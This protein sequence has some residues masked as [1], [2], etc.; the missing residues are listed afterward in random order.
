MKIIDFYPNRGYFL[1]GNDAEFLLEL[2]L[3]RPEEIIIG[4]EIVNLTKVVFSHNQSFDLVAGAHQI[5]LRWTTLPI[6]QKGYGVKVKIYKSGTDQLLGSVSTAFDVLTNWTDFPRYGYLCDF[7]KDRPD[8][9]TSLRTLLPFHINGLQFYDWQYC[10]DQLVPPTDSFID[11]LGRELSLPVIKELIQSAHQFGMAAMAYIAVYAASIGFWEKHKNWGMFDAKG[12]PHTF[13]GFLGLMDPSPESPWTQHLLDRCTQVESVLDFD[14]FHVDQYG[15]P[16]QAFTSTGTEIDIPHAFAAFINELKE[17]SSKPT[18]VFNAVGNWPIEMLAT[19]NQDFMYIEIWPPTPSYTDIEE[20]VISAR[21]KSGDKPVVIAQYLH[22]N[23]PANIR[24]SN[25]V[26]MACGGTRIEL[27]EQARLLADPYFPKHEKIS[28]ELANHL[29]KTSDFVVRYGELLGPT[30]KNIK[31]LKTAVPD[32]ITI[33][34]RETKNHQIINL[35][36]MR[37]LTD[38]KWT[39]KHLAPTTLEKFQIEIE[40]SRQI[41]EISWASPDSDQ[42]DLLPCNY[43]TEGLKVTIDIP[44]LHYWTMIVIESLNTEG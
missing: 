14:G 28:Q 29:R 10:H 42:I 24:L 12:T 16:K 8:T 35:V 36:N 3:D 40:P 11:P 39:E 25:S 37:G 31:T 30:A 41:N 27:G 33:I 43:R 4:I 20:T 6:P 26:I 23:Q 32:N 21:E 18:V 13:E 17:R 7:Q 34:C 9:F 19:T 38:P 2:R 5:P 1:P 15:E 22:T 44:I